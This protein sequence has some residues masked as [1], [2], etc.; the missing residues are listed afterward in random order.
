VPDGF[1][2]VAGAHRIAAG[3]LIGLVDIAANVVDLD[4]ID[5]RLAEIDENLI[6]SDLSV[7][8]RGEHLV[9]RKR[10][11][12]LKHPDT[13]AGVAGGKARQRS[14]TETVSVAAFATET[15]GR[16]GV[17]LSTRNGLWLILGA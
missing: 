3:R 2:L 17:C 14:A 8:E 12:L 7:L 4:D 6:H 5:A 11:Y 16:L 9:E 13:A 15:A 10:L 1:E